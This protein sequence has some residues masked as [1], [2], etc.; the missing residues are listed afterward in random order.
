M[1]GGDTKFQKWQQQ[2]WNRSVFGFWLPPL[3]LLLF[4][5]ASSHAFPHTL[6]GEKGQLR[7]RERDTIEIGGGGQLEEHR[8]FPEEKKG[9]RFLIWQR[10]AFYGRWWCCHSRNYEFYLP[11]FSCTFHAMKNKIGVSKILNTFCFQAF[12]NIERPINTLSTWQQIFSFQNANWRTMIS[13]VVRYIDRP[14]YGFFPDQEKARCIHPSLN[15]TFFWN[16]IGSNG[17][18][19]E[20]E[21]VSRKCDYWK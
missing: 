2:T 9:Q 14:C 3:C 21:K 20:S 5:F 7:K 19:R 18:E 4:L 17:R 1:C 8:C 6:I 15:A 10:M 13:V 16:R 11:I 12:C